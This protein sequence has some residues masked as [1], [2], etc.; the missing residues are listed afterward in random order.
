MP[1]N[2]TRMILA[3]IGRFL[4]DAAMILTLVIVG[5]VIANHF[6]ESYLSRHPDILLSPDELKGQAFRKGRADLTKGFDERKWFDLP[7]EAEIDVM[8]SEYYAAAPRF[9]SYV[10]FRAPATLGKYYR[11][12]EAGYRETRDPGPWPPDRRNY[13]VFFFGG[14]TAFGV[15]PNFTTVASYLQDALG[16]AAGRKV[17]VYNF[18]ASSYHSTQEKILFMQLL[19]EGTTAPDMVV[20]FDGLNDFCF[21]DG[22]PS[23]WR[24]LQSLYDNYHNDYMARMRGN[25]LATNWALARDFLTS[26]PLVRLAGAIG[27]RASAPPLPNYTKKDAAPDEPSPPRAELDRAMN[28]YAVNVREISAV[29]RAA[30]IVPVF[31]WQP[32]P[33]YKYDLR[34]HPLMPD[35]LSCHVGSKFGYPIMAQRPPPDVNFIWAADLQENLKDALYVDGFHYTAPFS[36]MVADHVAN[37]IRSQGMIGDAAAK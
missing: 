18:G 1:L 28:R 20:F 34:Y 22:Q 4:A 26:L 24:L 15:G 37:A 12:T 11:V 19:S 21:T 36:K 7:S 9:E 16:T 13:N 27:T 29:A 31:V 2:R 35:Q 25:G 14:S 8:W 30:S 3:N 5:L 6:A 23:N 10:H 32:I 17:Y 33:T